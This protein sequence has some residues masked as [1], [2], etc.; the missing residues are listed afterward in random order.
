MNLVSNPHVPALGVFGLFLCLVPPALAQIESTPIGVVNA[1]INGAPYAGETLEVPSEGTA[2]AEFRSFGPVTSLTVQALDPQAESMMHNVL[3][4]EISLM[5]ETASA[6]IM[7]ASVSYWPGGMS[8]PFYHSEDSGT[9][10]EI[11]L[12]ALSLSAGASAITGSFTAVVC[13]KDDFFAETDT[14]DCLP[15]EGSFDTALRKAD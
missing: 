15:V 9:G 13:R 5:G 14:S 12:D 10:T 7:E 2:T 6:S 11:V 3:S 1:T 4:V 8:A